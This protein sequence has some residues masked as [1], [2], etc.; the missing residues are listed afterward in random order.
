ASN[1]HYD[2]DFGFG[3][4]E[5]FY[6]FVS[7][8][9]LHDPDRLMA[10]IN[11]IGFWTMVPGL[12]LFWCAVW[13]RHGSFAATIA[14]V[15]FA[16]GPM[17]PEMY[18]SGHQTIP[19]FAFLCAGATLL[20][21]P[22]SGWKAVLAGTAASVLLLAGLITRGEIF[23]AFPWLVLAR[24]NTRSV[25]SFI[26]SGFI[27]SI[28]PASA[29]IAFLIL[30]HMMQSVVHEELSATVDNYF[31]EFYASL[32]T[33]IPGLI[34]MAIG[35]GIVTV[36]TAG[37]AGLY[38]LFGGKADGV[39]AELGSAPE[40]LGPLALVLVPML[41]FLPNPVP[42]RHFELPLAGMAILIGMALSRR[43]ALGR[44]AALA[45]ALLI[46]AGN[47]L[48]S[49]AVRPT[50]LRINQA[51]SP[52]LPLHEA[53]PTATHADIGLEWRRH[54]T[55][56]DKRAAWN[57]F[58]NKIRTSC[59]PRL[60]VLSDEVEQ[61]FSRLYAGSAKV[62]AR[63][64]VIPVGPNVKTVAVPAS[65]AIHLALV[66]KGAPRLPGFVGVMDGKTFVMLEKDHAWPY[67]PVAAVLADPDLDG[68]KIVA[69]PYTLS[70]FDRTPIPADRVAHFGCA[71]DGGGQ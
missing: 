44:V 58:G 25:R 19:M 63:R 29:L 22:L 37:I 41:F 45:L 51:H 67:D 4:L 11:A 1:L 48:A 57:A 18:T 30:K 27:R 20:F 26:V 39:R 47:Q 52:Y 70:Q 17:N 10:L 68:Y 65:Q 54:A 46:G 24:V 69:D 62:K 55:L 9:V 2:R 35:C 33:I 14:L 7:P 34:Y 16:F 28:P 5:A 3:Y 50:L 13:I 53:Y 32:A 66:G 56:V 60:V 49:A 61:I 42:T 38:V 12:L 43:P 40:W 59:D 21:L 15:I 64:I 6:L 36:L 23:L 71:A 8:A 31:Q